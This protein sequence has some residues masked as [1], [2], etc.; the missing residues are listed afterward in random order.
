VPDDDLPCNE[1]VEL[2]TC[3]LEDALDE[4]T[5]A[6]FEEH[7]LVCDGCVNYLTQMRTTIEAGGRL[8]EWDI[9]PAAMAELVQAFRGWHARSPG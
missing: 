4:R 8:A 6:R 1:L 3:Y 7:L 9:A 5:R 2:V